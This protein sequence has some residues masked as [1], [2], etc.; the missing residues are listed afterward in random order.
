MG[1]SGILVASRC[2]SSRVLCSSC[3]NSATLCWWSAAHNSTLPWNVA[4]CWFLAILASP[5]K[6]NASFTRDSWI[7]CHTCRS[8]ASLVFS[9]I[10]CHTFQ[11]NVW[12]AFAAAASSLRTQ[13]SSIP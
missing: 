2:T 11:V 4:R 1:G 5:K 7:A 9:M 13:A 12:Y 6:D 10:A 8:V 3:C